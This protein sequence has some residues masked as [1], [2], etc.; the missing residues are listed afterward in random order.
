MEPPPPGTEIRRL[1][2]G[3]G[4]SELCFVVFT[5]VWQAI[6]PILWCTRSYLAA[7]IHAS[8][9]HSFGAG[10]SSV[11]FPIYAHLRSIA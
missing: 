3:G 4:T 2:R 8:P 5:A 7:E 11:Y 1:F 10:R 9:T 6:C